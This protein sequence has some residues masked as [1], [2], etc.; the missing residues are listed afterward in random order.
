MSLPMKT[1]DDYRLSHL[2]RGETYDAYV[3]DTPFDAYMAEWE[4]R[5]VSAIVA[6]LFPDRVP[7]YLDFA[8]GTARV[9]ATVAA[10]SRETVG[11]DISAGMLE[12]ARRRLPEATFHE[13]DITRQPLELGQFDLI[14]AFRFF[15]N[16]QDDLRDEALRALVPRL[17]P[18]GFLLFNNHRNPR[19]LYALLNR[20]TGGTLG[21][22]DLHHAKMRRMLDRHGLAIR[23]LHPIGTWM[24]RSALMGSCRPDSPE[25]EARERRFSTPLLAGLAPD[26]VVVAQRR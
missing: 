15:G 18:G 21:S 11:V 12:V 24:W 26:A 14:S 4:R 25:A 2:Q 13:C 10:H 8:C 6:R 19:A 22:M 17:A 23:E 1:T 20:A 7:R 9:T 5:H 16:A 3:N